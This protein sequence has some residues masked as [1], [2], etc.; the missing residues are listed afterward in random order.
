MVSQYES[1]L[2][3]ECKTF[4]VRDRRTENDTKVRIIV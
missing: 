1:V 4:D 3:V 2:Y